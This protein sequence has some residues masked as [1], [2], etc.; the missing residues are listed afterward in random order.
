MQ[1]K[2]YFSVTFLTHDSHF[3]MVSDGKGII[4]GIVGLVGQKGNRKSTPKY[5]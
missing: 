3:S 4:I 5:F 1:L 2:Y